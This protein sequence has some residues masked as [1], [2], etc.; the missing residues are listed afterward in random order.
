M[1]KN[2]KKWVAALR[3]GKFKKA[4][5]QLRKGEDRFCCLGVAC[6]VAKKAGVISG[7]DPTAGGLPDEV[8]QWLGLRDTMGAFEMGAFRKNSDYED[9]TEINDKNHRFLTIADFIESE[10]AGLFTL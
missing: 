6:E 5:G 4:T 7:Y 9:L 10:P 3:S 1:N 8:Q 2:A